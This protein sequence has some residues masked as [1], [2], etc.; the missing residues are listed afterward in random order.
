MQKITLLYHDNNCFNQLF[1]FLATVSSSPKISHSEVVCV[2]SQLNCDTITG[3]T[4]LI[5]SC[6]QSSK[7]PWHKVTKCKTHDVTIHDGIR[8]N[9]RVHKS[10]HRTAM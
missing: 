7:H 8:P 10:S 3:V 6:T 9:L 1:S 2:E 5:L 4:N